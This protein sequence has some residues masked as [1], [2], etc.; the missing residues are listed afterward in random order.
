MADDRLFYASVTYLAIVIIVLLFLPSNFALTQKELNY[1]EALA[2]ADEGGLSSAVNIGFINK[3][4]R[5]FFI[6]FVVGGTPLFVSSVIAFMNYMTLII[7]VIW[8]YNKI[9][10]IS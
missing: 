3:L 6:P 2:S 7:G 9:R 5:L 1:N 10:G 8:G 4:M